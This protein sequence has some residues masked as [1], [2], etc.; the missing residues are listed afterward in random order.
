VISSVL[1]WQVYAGP[2][3]GPAMKRAQA[4]PIDLGYLREVVLPSANPVLRPKLAAAAADLESYC[5]SF[6]TFMRDVKNGS[7]PVVKRIDRGRW[8]AF[9]QKPDSWI[10]A[11]FT[12]KAGGIADGEEFHTR[13]PMIY[14]FEFNKAGYVI[15]AATREESFEFD[16]HGRLTHWHKDKADYWGKPGQ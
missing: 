4:Q 8:Q 5:A 12:D 15:Y 9:V 14:R 1:A 10:S 6:D 3:K 13:G 2:E 11:T 16:D 7:V